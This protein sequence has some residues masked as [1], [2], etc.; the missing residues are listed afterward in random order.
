MISRLGPNADAQK[1]LDFAPGELN[2][3]PGFTAT[4]IGTPGMVDGHKSFQ[5]A[6]SWNSNGVTK[7]ITQNTVVIQDGTGL[8]VMQINIDGVADQAEI[9]KQIT[10]AID[11]D[12]KIASG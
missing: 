6:G 11:R 9:I 3:L 10:E 12:T 4:D 1:I 7:L 8:Y 2:N 5:I